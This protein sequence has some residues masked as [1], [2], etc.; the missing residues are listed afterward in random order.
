[1]AIDRAA[2]LAYLAENA[3]IRSLVGGA[4]YQGLHDRID[5]GDFDNEQK[6]V[7]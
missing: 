6:E 3:A 2:L 7:T 1:M 5:R 4:I